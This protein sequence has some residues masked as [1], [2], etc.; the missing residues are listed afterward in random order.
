M[1]RTI[2]KKSVNQ[3]LIPYNNF[4]TIV[5]GNA[6]DLTIGCP[7]EVFEGEKRVAMTPEN[8]AKLTKTGFT[9]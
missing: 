2:L 5:H 8:T 7:K 1:L 3:S 6:K 9:V 4:C